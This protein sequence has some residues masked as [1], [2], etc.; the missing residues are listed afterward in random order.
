MGIVVLL[1]CKHSEGF[2]CWGLV[3]DGQV[4]D[5]VSVEMAVRVEDLGLVVEVVVEMAMKVEGYDFEF[6]AADFVSD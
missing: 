2:Y 1:P 6:A 4:V 5:W 3:M